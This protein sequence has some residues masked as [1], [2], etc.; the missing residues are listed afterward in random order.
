VHWTEPYISTRHSSS[1]DVII[2]IQTQVQCEATPIGTTCVL[3]NVAD[4]ANSAEWTELGFVATIAGPGPHT[5]TI[6]GAS[7][8]NVRGENDPD[9]TNNTVVLELTNS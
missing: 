1:S 5:I 3:A 2:T 8:G 6:T 7:R 4:K 9:Q